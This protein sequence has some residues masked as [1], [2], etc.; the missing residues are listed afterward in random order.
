MR[1]TSSKSGWPSPSGTSWGHQE[2][3]FNF[4]QSLKRRPE[5][6][7]GPS[8]PI[9]TVASQEMVYRSDNFFYRQIFES[10]R[11]IKLKTGWETPIEEGGSTL[12]GKLAFHFAGDQR[13]KARAQFFYRKSIHDQGSL[14]SQLGIHATDAPG[15]DLKVRWKGCHALWFRLLGKP[16]PPFG[17]SEARLDL[18]LFRLRFDEGDNEHTL[19]STLTFQRLSLAFSLGSTYFNAAMFGQQNPR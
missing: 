13:N 7:G 3:N 10:T 8:L 6:S 4:L 14:Q 11:I 9:F 1:T 19:E 16:A 18:G 2:S 12:G 17:E 15:S 5:R